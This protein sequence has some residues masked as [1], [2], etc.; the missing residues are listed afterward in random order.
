MQ[1]LRILLV[2]DHVLFRK[3]V[4]SLLAARQDF[5]VVGE[6]GDGR[7]GIAQA[8]RTLPDVILMDIGMPQCSGLEA[9]R[10]IK[11]EMPHVKIIMLTISDDDRDLFT[12]IKN[13][14]D[15]YLLKNLEPSQL[16]DMLNG[17]SRGEVAI[18]GSIAIKILNEFRQPDPSLAQQEQALDE[19]TQRE[20]DVLEHVT[21][22]ASN[23]EIA[24]TLSITENT[25]KIHLRNIL[26]KLHLHNRIQVAVYAVHQ[27]LV[28]NPFQ[29]K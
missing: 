19:L 18:S 10:L 17:A 12:A 21:R 16:F 9:T 4:A 2:D 22:G 8:R 24:A 27:G 26:D 6:A 29:E 13:G 23:K 14:A 11:Q 25:V 28:P 1:P 3:G 15:G 5:E 20:V 7:E